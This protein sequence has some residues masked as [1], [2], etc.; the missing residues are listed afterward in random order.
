M[1]IIESSISIAVAKYSLGISFDMVDLANEM[2]E[3]GYDSPELLML[4]LPSEAN[5]QTFNLAMK[6]NGIMIPER[7][8][9]RSIMVRYYVKNV[10]DNHGNIYGLREFRDKMHYLFNLK[11]GVYDCDEDVCEMLNYYW[12]LDDNITIYS[13]DEVMEM[14]KNLAIKILDKLNKIAQQGDAPE[15]ATNAVSASQPSIPPAR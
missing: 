11:D 7:Q 6:E 3:S 5:D 12:Y 1:N 8:V 9:A 10:L 4:S 14:V 2:I 15:P 13:D